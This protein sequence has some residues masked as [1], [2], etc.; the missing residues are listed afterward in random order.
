VKIFEVEIEGTTPLLHHRM[1]PETL[2][3]LLGGKKGGKKKPI[4]PRTPR[5]I[6][7]DHAYKDT[8]G[9]LVFPMTYICGAFR[10]VSGDYKQK[11][12]SRKSYKSIAGGIFRPMT[13]F[14]PVLDMK[15]KKMKKFEVDIKKATNHLK[16][17]VAVCRPRMDR[18][19][20]KFQISL[21]E[22]IITSE[23]AL[24]ILED[25]G[26]RAGI[27]SFRVSKGGHY[28]QF[29]VTRWKQIKSTKRQHKVVTS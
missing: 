19:K 29:Q 16:G 22:E 6:A 17:A 25:A 10:E 11:D 20:S 27:G 3:L 18:W 5:E 4:N 8:S 23:T 14:A 13:E 9:N 15:G 12:S 28:G 1:T 7:E 2:S 24:Q 21:D 26:R